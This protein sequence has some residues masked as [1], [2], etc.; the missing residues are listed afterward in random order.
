[1][2][3][4]L[5]LGVLEGSR[6]FRSAYLSYDGGHSQKTR[7]KY[8]IRNRKARAFELLVSAMLLFMAQSC[9]RQIRKQQLRICLEVVV[10]KWKTISEEV[11]N[12]KL[13]RL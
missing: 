4:V 6:R 3:M 9:E 1:M 11:S 13:G 8:D 2:T 10:Q 7:L 12:P 5:L